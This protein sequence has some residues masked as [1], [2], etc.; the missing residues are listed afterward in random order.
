MRESGAGSASPYSTTSTFMKQISKKELQSP[1]I[2]GYQ[3]SWLFAG[4]CFVI[5]TKQVGFDFDESCDFWYSDNI[6]AEQLR[7][8]G[9]KHILVPDSVVDHI[10]SQTINTLPRKE[11]MR[12]TEGML[13]SYQQWHKDNPE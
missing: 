6:V 8:A 10:E 2:E 1:W 11:L 4:W 5:D 12:V 7:R 13:P 9:I 3:V